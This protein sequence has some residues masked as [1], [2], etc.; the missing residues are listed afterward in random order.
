MKIFLTIIFLL[1]GLYSNSE[2]RNCSIIVKVDGLKKVQG[3]IAAMIFNQADG[4]PDKEENALASKLVEVKDAAPIII[5][6]NLPPGKYAVSLIHDV[7]GNRDLDKNFIG[8]PTEPFGFSG[9]KSIFR[10][11]PNFDDAAIDLNTTLVES[12]IKLVEIF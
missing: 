1:A 5:F 3:N 6:S 2:E 4:F 7:N 10:G 8:I 9:N 11:L 12:R